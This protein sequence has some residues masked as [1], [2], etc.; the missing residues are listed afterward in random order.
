MNVYDINKWTGIFGGTFNPVHLGHINIALK[1]IQLKKVEQVIFIPALQPPHKL[2]DNIAPQKH[3]LAMLKL[4][5]QGNQ[6]LFISDHELN[7][8]AVSYTINT[9]SYFAEIFGNNLFL[10]IG[11][12]SLLE[13]YTWHKAEE[14]VN[15]YQFIIYSRPDYDITNQNELISYFGKT[16]TEKLMASIV[17]DEHYF[18]SSSKIRQ[19]IQN[20]KSVSKFL[21]DSVIDYIEKHRL[22]NAN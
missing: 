12:D 16:D 13:L 1:L 14:L 10:I 5:V 3:R 7:R 4:A 9:A 15:R 20:G 8:K 6:N 17:M 19:M 21:Q 11:S 18:L 22:Y 2:K